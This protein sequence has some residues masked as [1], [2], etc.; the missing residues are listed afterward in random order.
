MDYVVV[1]AH[2]EADMNVQRDSFT[3]ADGH[4]IV[5]AEMVIRV[6]GAPTEAARA[7]AKTIRE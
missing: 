6:K 1:R 4:G 3:L 2:A 7:W 5:C